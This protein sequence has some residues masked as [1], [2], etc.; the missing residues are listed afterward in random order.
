MHT[1]LVNVKYRV[2][3]CTTVEK[4]KQRA[5]LVRA[6][7]APDCDALIVASAD[8]HLALP[9]EGTLLCVNTPSMPG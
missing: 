8:G 3:E 2:H 4:A 1:Q 6:I 9:V 5:A 7:K